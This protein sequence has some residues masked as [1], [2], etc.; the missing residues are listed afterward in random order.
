M[1]VIARSPNKHQLCVSMRGVPASL[2]V[3]TDMKE[4]NDETDEN[5]KAGA[6]SGNGDMDFGDVV[7]DDGDDLCDD[8]GPLSRIVVST[9]IKA[10][11]NDLQLARQQDRDLAAKG[12]S[13]EEIKPSKSVV[14]SQWTQMLDLLE[15]PLKKN[16]FKYTRF[17]ASTLDLT[18]ECPEIAELSGGVGLNLTHANRVY[19]MEPYWNP[20]VEQQAVDR[21][22]RLERKTR[23]ARLTFREED[24]SNLSTSASEESVTGRKGKKAAAAGARKA[25][26]VAAEK[27]REAQQAERLSDLK[28]LL[29]SG[30]KA[31][32]SDKILLDL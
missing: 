32:N 17:D 24:A 27:S 23:L 8:N 16:G 10:L 30:G 1:D 2:D 29:G 11:I 31:E 7:D 26:K 21:I 20:A 5:S 15:G 12:S 28:A 19:V 3:I 4:V 9:K 22:H 6:K 18:A 13:S 25:A 14:F